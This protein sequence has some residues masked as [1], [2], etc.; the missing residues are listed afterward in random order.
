MKALDLFCGAGGVSVGLHRAGFEPFGI[1]IARQP[2]YPFKYSIANA[3]DL[4]TRFLRQFDLIW[5]SPP[6]QL[7]T[8]MSGPR[9]GPIARRRTERSHPDL[10]E[11]TRRMLK[12]AGVPYVIENVP[13]APLINPIM[14]CGTMFPELRVYRHR[15]FETSHPIP[16]PNHPAHPSTVKPLTLIR[17]PKYPLFP[18]DYVT[19]CGN[20]GNVEYAAKA[21]QIDWMSGHEMSQAIPPPF[22]HHIAL[23]MI[24]YLRKK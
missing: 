2:R 18:G 24:K 4:P 6:C 7:Y 8:K 22:A 9:H 21:M 12:K 23:A 3:L 5:A 17:H 1:D 16:Q 15:L 14:L 19:V 13:A 20:I 11:P 10:I